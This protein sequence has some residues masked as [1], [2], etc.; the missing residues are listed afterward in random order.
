MSILRVFVVPS[1][2]LGRRPAH[3][4]AGKGKGGKGGRGRVKGQGS[5][6]QSLRLVHPRQLC[7][8]C[9]L[10]YPG[11]SPLFLQTLFVQFFRWDGYLHEA[12]HRLLFLIIYMEPLL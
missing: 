11:R 12:Q 7:Y 5:T 1:P 9:Y 8:L 4:T 2:T 3:R 10:F 6:T